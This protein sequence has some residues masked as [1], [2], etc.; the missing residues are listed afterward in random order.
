VKSSVAAGKLPAVTARALACQ[1]AGDYLGMADALGPWQDE[2]ALDGRS[3][4]YAQLWRPLLAEGLIGSGQAE[5][6]AVV[7]AQLRAGSGRHSRTLAVPAL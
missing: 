5:R 2:A 7:L 3:R 1:A 6:A 4:M